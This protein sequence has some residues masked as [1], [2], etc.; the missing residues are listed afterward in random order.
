MTWDGALVMGSGSV[1]YLG[2]GSAAE[3]HAHDAIQLVWGV[4]G[5]VRVASDDGDVE[6][7]AAIIPS[8]TAHAIFA[9]H[10]RLALILVEPLGA[11]G[12]ALQRFAANHV[13]SDLAPRLAAH[14]PPVWPSNAIHVLAWCDG[15]VASLVPG[16]PTPSDDAAIRPEVRAAV[17]Y[18]DDALDAVPRLADAARRVGLSPTRLTH[19]FS[20]Q[21]GMPFRRFVLWSRLRRAALAVKAGADLTEA[22]A[23]AG[24]ADSAHFSRVF[25]A[26]FGLAP[27]T[28]LPHLE[29]ADPDRLQD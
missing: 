22:A 29:I 9:D 17:R 1:V 14:A 4:D 11:R 10:T 27:S 21:V 7:G 25:R 24:F 16:A 20:A 6:M 5:T 15:L 26:T 28:V 3:W 2:P 8:R 13:R 23:E 18:V 19:L 12:H